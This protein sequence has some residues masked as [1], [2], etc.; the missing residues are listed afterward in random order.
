M[1]AF[2]RHLLGSL[3]ILCGTRRFL[4]SQDLTGDHKYFLFE[5]KKSKK[6]T[7]EQRKN[8]KKRPKIPKAIEQI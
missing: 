8:P 6:S 3:G 4:A 2:I 1:I 7:K 5:R